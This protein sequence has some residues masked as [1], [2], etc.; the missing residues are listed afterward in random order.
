MARFGRG[1]YA[2]SRRVSPARV[3]VAQ[4]T[5][6]ERSVAKQVIIARVGDRLDNS[7]MLQ[8][9][10]GHWPRSGDVVAFHLDIARGGKP[11][12]LMFVVPR[13]A[14]VSMLKTEIM[15]TTNQPPE[16]AIPVAQFRSICFYRVIDK[17]K[18]WLETADPEDEKDVLHFMALFEHQVK[19][20]MRRR[21]LEVTPRIEGRWRRYSGVRTLYMSPGTDGER[22]ACRIAVV[23]IVKQFLTDMNG[24]V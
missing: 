10:T 1:R 9:I 4:A 5:E 13:T 11:K 15:V 16:G 23:R 12:A 7:P 22:E 21:T 3:Y 6:A 8:V 2:G 18:E 24:G 14:P 19:D 20:A 17:M